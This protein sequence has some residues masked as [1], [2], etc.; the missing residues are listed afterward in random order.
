MLNRT[1]CAK[2]QC[3]SFN[4]DK[5]LTNS[6]AFLVGIYFKV[7][8]NGFDV[9]FIFSSTLGLKTMGMCSTRNN[10]SSYS[11]LDNAHSDI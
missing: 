7:L 8:N 4:L 11:V 2:R 1:L 10:M 3:E 6:L 5:I 9:L